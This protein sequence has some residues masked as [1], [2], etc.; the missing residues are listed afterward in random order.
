MAFSVLAMD[1]SCNRDLRPQKYRR[2]RDPRQLL[3]GAS[4]SAVHFFP[5]TACG[6]KITESSAS[7]ARNASSYPLI[8]MFGRRRAQHRQAIPRSLEISHQKRDEKQCAQ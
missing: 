3:V 7:T 1:P 5:G 8:P 4:F 2:L 6:L